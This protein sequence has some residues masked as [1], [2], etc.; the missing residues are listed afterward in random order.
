[1]RTSMSARAIRRCSRVASR[2][3]AL[4]QACCWHSPVVTNTS[5]EPTHPPQG[6]I[7]SHLAE[8]HSDGGGDAE[9]GAGIGEVLE[10]DPVALQQDIRL[11]LQQLGTRR[12]VVCHCVLQLTPVRCHLHRDRAQPGSGAPSIPRPCCGTLSPVKDEG[13]TQK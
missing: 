9:R 7:S 6:D 5:L 13:S 3:S 8:G 2:P 1:M 4:R 10:G 12:C 11:V